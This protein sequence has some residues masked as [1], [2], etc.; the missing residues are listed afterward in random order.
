[1]PDAIGYLIFKVLPTLAALVFLI[2]LL[3]VRLRP[4]KRQAIMGKYKGDTPAY[5]LHNKVHSPRFL[6]GWS[7][8][9]LFF[10]FSIAFDL[11]RSRYTS[12][13]IVLIF[14]AII[15]VTVLPLGLFVLPS[16]FKK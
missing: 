4:A 15:S 9:T 16:L 1:M 10:V 13:L 3:Y 12:S 8:I 14:A 7:L 11:Y 5:T 2:Y 6:L